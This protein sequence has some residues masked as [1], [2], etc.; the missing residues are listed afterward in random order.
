MSKSLFMTDKTLMYK[1]NL[2]VA[3][4]RTRSRFIDDVRDMIV[5]DW[6]HSFYFFAENI[7]CR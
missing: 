1:T 5:V 6:I 4:N 7:R 3:N 2:C